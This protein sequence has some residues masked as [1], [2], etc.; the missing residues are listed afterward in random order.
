MFLVTL[1]MLAPFVLLAA[2]R[3]YPK[4]GAY[5][6]RKVRT[7]PLITVGA[8][9]TNTVVAGALAPASTAAY[10]LISCVYRWALSDHTAGEGPYTVGYAFGDYSVTEIKEA[11]EIANS[12][13]PSDKVAQEKANRWVRIVGTFAGDQVSE[14]LNDGKALKT[15]LN[16]FIPI[17]STVN[18][19]V[20]NEDNATQTTGSLID[21]SGNLWV[22]DT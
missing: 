11:I 20:Y 18:A 22:K 13:S 14:T 9:A 2:H 10:R 16:W 17:G 1:L 8:L 5:A 3:G 21:L 12:I 15:R 19:F 6:L 7:I 4:R